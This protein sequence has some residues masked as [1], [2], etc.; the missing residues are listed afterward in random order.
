MLVQ[1]VCLIIFHFTRQY[2][3]W[4]LLLVCRVSSIFGDSEETAKFEKSFPNSS[5]I[6]HR[7]SHLSLIDWLMRLLMM[8][9][10]HALII[11]L[12]EPLLFKSRHCKP[13][14]STSTNWS[15]QQSINWND[16]CPLNN[17]PALTLNTSS[18]YDDAVS[19]GCNTSWKILALSSTCLVPYLGLRYHLH[20]F[21]GR[22]N[23]PR[24]R[25]EVFNSR[26]AQLRSAIER[27][28]GVWKGRFRLLRNCAALKPTFH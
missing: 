14:N 6:L 19:R 13:S 16:H 5:C 24:I 15:I 1:R 18:I 2:W 12:I 7:N 20:E 9:H 26:H 11:W 10:S 23:V 21:C 25:E 27:T 28:I 17:E 3:C 4:F 22:G 8:V